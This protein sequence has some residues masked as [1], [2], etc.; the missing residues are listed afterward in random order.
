MFKILPVN[1]LN[2]SIFWM[3]LR[4]DMNTFTKFYVISKST[5][6][7]FFAFIEAKKDYSE[8]VFYRDIKYNLK[9]PNIQTKTY[10]HGWNNIILEHILQT[11][12]S[13]C[14]KFNFSQPTKKNWKLIRS[15]R[16]LENITLPVNINVYD[17]H[18]RAI[19]IHS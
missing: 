11:N 13:R 12:Q 3:R 6:H 9:W 7:L 16:I 10:S 19:A 14:Y 17:D 15:E 4:T 2:F 5:F 18:L 8:F 1:I